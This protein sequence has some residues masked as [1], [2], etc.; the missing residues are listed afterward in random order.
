MTRRFVQATLAVALLLVACGPSAGEG[1]PSTTAAPA[2][3][4]A[5]AA[6]SPTTTGSVPAATTTAAV[7]QSDAPPGTEAPAAPPA[8]PAALDRAGGA[9]QAV[10][11]A[12]G[13]YGSTTGT[14]TTWQRT[15]SGGWDQVHGPWPA[16]LG[17]AGFAPPGE[18]REGD[19]RTPSGT[20][21]FEF[22]F[23][24]KA[25]PGVALPYRR[26]TGP[27]IVWDDNP[28]SPTYNLWVDGGRGEPMYVT[29]AYDYGAVIAYNADRTPGLG[30]AIFLH[31]STGAPT[32][33]CVSLPVGQLLQVLRWLDPARSPAIVMGVS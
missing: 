22:L 26:V 9:G 6:S 24:V 19:G 7:P 20:Y 10:V 15:P 30:S 27:S 23:G 5:P 13:G 11:V 25:D 2:A 16:R 33:G 4:V 12:G 18:K 21:R 14:L 28:S 8:P 17:R 32:A 1:G 29:P 31:V 3:T